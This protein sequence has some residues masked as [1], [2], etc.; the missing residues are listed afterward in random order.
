[1]NKR[2]GLGLF[3][4]MA[5]GLP[6]VATLT[7]PQPAAAQGPPSAAAT[8]RDQED[9]PG[10]RMRE[11]ARQARALAA[12][13]KYA[14]ALPLAKQVLERT[15]KRLGPED[16]RTAAGLRLVANINMGLN[17]YRQAIP[18]YQRAL[19]IMEKTSGP[20][21][22]ETLETMDRL[23]RA[24]VA[25]GSYAEALSLGERTLAV[26]KRLSGPDDPDIAETLAN[27]A[28][29]QRQ[30]GALDKALSLAQES[31]KIREKALGPEHPETAGILET[32][33][34]IHQQ[35]GASEK[36]LP[37][38]ERAL[39]I[40]EKTLGPDHP[41]TAQAQRILG[42]IHKGRGDYTQA[43]S[44][45]KKGE[46]GLKGP[47]TAGMVEVYLGQGRYEQALEAL[48]AM[49]LPPW[50]PP[51]ILTQFHIQKG[52][53]LKGTGRLD[54]AALSF[55]EAIRIIEEMRGRAPGER[56]AFFQGGRFIAHYKAYLGLIGVLAE[57]AQKRQPLPPAFAAY[58]ADLASAAF[59][60]A[61]SIKAR[62]L[63]EAIAAKAGAGPG[64]ELPAE[65]AS[66]ERKLKDESAALDAK[67][68]E[69]YQP[70][71]G[72]KRDVNVF[73][74]E[75]EAWGKKQQ[76]LVEELRRRYPRYA[77]LYYPRPYKAAE[78]PLKSG[79]VLLE[80]T[81]GEKESYLF[82][83]E[84]GGRTQIIRLP[85]GQEQMGR[86][87]SAMLEPFR[88]SVLRREDLQKFS[89]NE[90]AAL[91]RE[92]LAPGLDGVAAGTRL[93]I[94]PDGILGAFPFEALVVQTA[95]DWGN[96]V[97]VGDRWPLTYYQSAAILAL[98]R[99][100]GV[101]RAPQPLF[102]LGDCI[103]E[104]ASPRYQAYKAGR[105]KAGELKSSGPE[106][107]LTMSAA[108]AGGGLQFA[109]LPE[110]RQ[111]VLELANLFGV[112]PQPPQV[113]LDV[114]A[115]ETRLRQAPLGQFRYLFF[116]THGFLADNLAGGQEPTLVLTQVENQAPENGFLTFNKV[117]HL[118]LDADLVALAAC[119]TGVGKV[120]QGEGVLNFA[121]AFQQAGARS[122]MVSLWNI[123]VEESL[124]FYSQFYQA[125][126]GGR[127]KLEA[128]KAARSSV[129][130][131]EP[132]PY[133]WTG[134]ILHGEG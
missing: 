114:L 94:V 41:R 89:Q 67:R 109:P 33:A 122:V 57:M 95:P 126:K 69:I 47:A 107:A 17:R 16:P 1:V 45:M 64:E 43:E 13:G 18:L 73:Q 105:E 27:L 49:R 12:A 15:E 60:F 127:P 29:V 123:P 32:L 75:V 128:L 96:S 44:A 101:S 130:A 80:Y 31:L 11:A 5:I 4:I 132:H 62:S 76:A 119:M 125:L 63:L 106:K 35:Q 22:P 50:A 78:L 9:T 98:N 42:L 120:T 81:L 85:W 133:F 97:L 103:Y 55:A 71:P 124:K 61:E 37:L 40:K 30:M 84:P 25:A 116:G 112:K 48:K 56:T 108:G 24:Y 79:E 117:L 36:A 74:T 19:K 110:T 2:F 46:A 20:E 82:R 129:R 134:L 92:I 8:S 93:I 77:A 102:A 53:A 51:Q 7:L 87:L 113:L 83:V 54:E 86:R 58:G 91:Y 59:Y 14:E 21:N 104:K 34:M 52:L 111:T 68:Q 118:R 28:E 100:L 131:K 90:A 72:M 121:R 23:T 39:K 6:A 65:L 66:R 99:H 38:A 115:T 70:H 88:Q 3:L 26:R 10:S